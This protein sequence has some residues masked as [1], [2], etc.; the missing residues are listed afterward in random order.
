MGLP[1]LN[2]ILK[3]KEYSSSDNLQVQAGLIGED[4][5][6]Y[7][8]NFHFAHS[9]SVMVLHDL[10]LESDGFTAQI[11]HLLI[12][13]LLEIYV[14]ETKAFKQGLFVDSSGD[15]YSYLG[16]DKYFIQ[17][18]IRQNEKHIKIIK[19]LIK[20][21]IISVPKRLGFTLPVD[22]KNIVL[23]P[24]DYQFI[25]EDNQENKYKSIMKANDFFEY[26]SKDIGNPFV[27]SKLLSTSDLVSFAEQF[28]SLH[29]TFNQGLLSEEKNNC[30]SCNVSISKAVIEFC[31]RN[32]TVFGGE[33]YCIP[34][35]NKIRMN[36]SR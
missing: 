19:R 27:L 4:K 26:F 25:N 15:F 23:I 24:N 11:D 28:N 8:L 16:S 30:F 31:S 32:T 10:F 12:T 35:Q 1:K 21:K 3:I 13:K 33:F 17:S 18:P 20:N 6:A 14:I 9:N 5:I 36:F 22:F 29:S 2:M 34:C 7:E